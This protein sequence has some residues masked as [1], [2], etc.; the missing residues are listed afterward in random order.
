MIGRLMVNAAVFALGFYLGKQFGLTEH[1]RKDL[2]GKRA[3]KHLPDQTTEEQP[4]HKTQQHKA[5]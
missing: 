2:E 1:I 4:A 3:Q 5:S